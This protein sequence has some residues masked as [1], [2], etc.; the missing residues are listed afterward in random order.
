MMYFSNDSHGGNFRE[1]RETILEDLL[2][3]L[4]ETAQHQWLLVPLHQTVLA[5][6][7]FP[8]ACHFS[9]PIFIL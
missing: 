3:N 8:Y 1:E 2:L 6:C 9:Y 7:E 4:G 5:P